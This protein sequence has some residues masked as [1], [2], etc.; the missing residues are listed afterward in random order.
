MSA[1]RQSYQ[2]VAQLALDEPNEIAAGIVEVG[3]LRRP[4]G[5]GLISKLN[6]S[7]PQALEFGGDV[8]CIELRQRN[9]VVVKRLLQRD[10]RR[11]TGRFK[12]KLD[13]IGIVGRDEREQA[14]SP[15]GMSCLMRKPSTS[16]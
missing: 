12:Q 15:T 7:G 16:L 9:A 4:H 14:A 3:K 6:A 10:C 2:R 8:V 5:L 13:A 11:M 1:Q